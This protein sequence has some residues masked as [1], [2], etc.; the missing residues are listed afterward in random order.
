M[1]ATVRHGRGDDVAVVVLEL[2]RYTGQTGFSG[3]PHSVTVLIQEYRAADR[4]LEEEDVALQVCYVGICLDDLAQRVGLEKDIE[5][6]L[7]ERFI[8]V[9]EPVAVAEAG[10]LIGEDPREQRAHV[11]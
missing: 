2:H 3:I 10:E 6:I 4:C 1:T 8:E 11:G 7:V 5:L 9:E